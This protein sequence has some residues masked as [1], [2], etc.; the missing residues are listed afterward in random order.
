ML[1][2]SLFIS[3]PGLFEITISLRISNTLFLNVCGNSVRKWVLCDFLHFGISSSSEN[4]TKLNDQPNF[5]GLGL[6][7]ALR[8]EFCFK[9]M[10]AYIRFSAF[11][12]TLGIMVK[13]LHCG[14]VVKV[15]Y[16]KQELHLLIL[17][18]L[19]KK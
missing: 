9:L 18:R 4:G 16:R 11:Y 7:S 8:V 1:L 2:A 17:C 10:I 13:R 5:A 15:H 3:F 19:S 14:N 6:R 12:V